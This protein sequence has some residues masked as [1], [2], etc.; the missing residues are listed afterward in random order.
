MESVYLVCGFHRHCTNAVC[1]VYRRITIFSPLHASG[2]GIVKLLKQL[3]SIVAHDTLR[4]RN[5]VYVAA[6]EKPER[7]TAR[8]APTVRPAKMRS[9]NDPL[10]EASSGDLEPRKRTVT[11]P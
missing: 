8:A 3:A 5:E 1:K 9:S 4:D 11:K 2:I 7:L 6:D 10:S